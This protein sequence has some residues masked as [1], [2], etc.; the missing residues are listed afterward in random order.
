MATTL[1]GNSVSNGAD[2]RF[3]IGSNLTPSFEIGIEA[4]DD[5]WLKAEFVGPNKDEP[6]FNGRLFHGGEG[7]GITTVIDNFPKADVPKGWTKEIS[8]DSNGYAL[9]DDLGNTLFS[10]IDTG[11]GD[12]LVTVKLYGANGQIVALSSPS[13]LSTFGISFKM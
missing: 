2:R 13:G 10:Y 3:D 1:S 4:S 6:L 5:A 8:L 9:I 7:G 11:E 12:V